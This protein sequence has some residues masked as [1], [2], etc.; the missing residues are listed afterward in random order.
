M[1]DT[2]ITKEQVKKAIEELKNK[3]SQYDQGCITWQ[4]LSFAI[5]QACHITEVFLMRNT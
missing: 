1:N 2:K 4:E 5:I 3:S